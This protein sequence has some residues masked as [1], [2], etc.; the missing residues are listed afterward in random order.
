[1][2]SSI[3]YFAYLGVMV[4]AFACFL[5]AFRVRFDTPRHKRWGVTGVALSLGGIAVVLIGAYAW[6]WTVPERW[7][8]VVLWHRRL[9]YAGTALIVLV[10][11]TGALR[12]RIHKKL[13]IVFLPVYAIVLVLAILGYRP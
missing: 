12:L 5:Q 11:V 1:M 2:P 6:G 3:L 7:P 10:G 4:A 13:Y 8:Q 9:A